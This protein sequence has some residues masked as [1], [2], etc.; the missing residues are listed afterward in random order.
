MPIQKHLWRLAATVRAELASRRGR[1]RFVELPTWSWDRCATACRQ[2]RR[3]EL[4][5]WN[6]A[7]ETLR[8][9]LGAT[10]RS[11]VM[12]LTE[13][14]DQIPRAPSPERLARTSHI[15]G[16]LVALADGFDRFEYD[17]R[18]QWLR[19]TTEPITLDGTYLG[20]F[21]IRLAWGQ[22]GAEFPYR[23]IATDPHPAH[24]RD[25]VTHPHVMDEHLCEGEARTAI[26]QALAQGRL[27]DFFTL[28][29]NGLRSYNPDSPFV[30]LDVWQ[31]ASCSDC[32]AYVDDDEGRT[33]ATCEGTVCD[34][35]QTTCAR[36]DESCCSSCSLPCPH[37]DETCC[38]GCLRPCPGCRTRVCGGCFG[39]DDERCT[40]CYEEEP[41]NPD[42]E[43][44]S[45]GAP[46]QPDGLGQAPLP[47]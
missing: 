26:R 16:D 24:S 13:L 27:L 18:A 25:S 19:V 32:G 45:C 9:E 17:L 36:C 23:V 14:V 40:H 22:P 5:G 20:P 37:C 7:A 28:I 10:L 21:E 2:I 11:L 35:C 39:P 42:L 1:D 44:A 8:R 29:A 6:L 30:A 38:R 43:P 12:E 3:A 46:L 41:S 47:A 15:Y 34:D 31:G 4:R 33:C